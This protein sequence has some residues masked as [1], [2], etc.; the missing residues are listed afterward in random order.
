MQFYAPMDLFLVTMKF[1]AKF[2]KL[3]RMVEVIKI[4]IYGR[5]EQS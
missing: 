2:G 4:N 3:K 5:Y 1:N